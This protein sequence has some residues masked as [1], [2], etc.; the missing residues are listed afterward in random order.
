MVAGSL[1]LALL[2]RPAPA[3]EP[4]AP[5]AG[6][7]A[8]RT[9]TPPRIDGSLEDAAWQ[10]EALPLG[11][12]LTYNPLNGEKLVQ[13]TEVR[14]VYDDRAIYLAFRCRDPEPEK[15]RS[16]LSR[17]DQLW[18]DDWVG[19][20]LDPV[21]NGQSSYDLFVNAAGVQA[22]ILTTPSAG[23]NS[24]PD[25]VWD[26]A[27]RRTSE[28]YE[29]EIRL[30]LTTLRFKSGAEVRMGILF[31]RRVSRLGM[32]ASWPE[33]PAGKSFIERH[34]TLT[35]H[36]LKQPLTLEVI[37]S[38]TYSRRQTRVSPEAFGPADS[39]PD[40]GISVK[41]GVTSSTTIEGTV[42]PD[43]SQVESDAFQV[44]VNQRFPVFYSEKRPFFMEGMGT[45]ELAGVGGD[46]NMRTAVNTRV[47]QDPLWGGKASGTAGRATFALLAAGDEAPGRQVPGGVVNPFLGERRG[48]FIGRGQYSIGSSNYVGALLTDTEFGGGHNRVASTD[49]SLK[50]GNHFTS[51]TF[52]ASATRGAD[53]SETKDGLAGQLS[54]A[55]ET[56]P[57]VAVTQV[58][59]YDTDFQM[60]TAFVNQTGVTQGWSFV[61]PSFYPDPKK[62]P[63]LKRIVPFVF[64]RYGKDRVQGGSGYFVLPGIRV[65]TTRQGFFRLDAG[66]GREPWA[67]QVF[68]TSQ[69]RLMGGAQPFR[70][71]NVFTQA[72]FGRS[73]YYDPE[74]PYSGR[75]R[76]YQ[77]EVS[78]QPSSRFN[79]SV[80]WSHV[81][82]DR[83]STGENVYTVD[84]LNTRTTFQFDRH[85]FLR[86][87]VQ[88]DS[89][90]HRV[91]TDF[92]ASWELLPG[93]V[94]YAGYGSIVERRGWDG[95]GFT[96][97]P[98][99]DYRTSQ[100][101]FFFKASYIHR[102]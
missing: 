9:E 35:L 82:F 70:W 50:L 97:D 33:V 59:H 40:I 43:F 73:I 36:D 14:V 66:W 4:P 2:A 23:E 47:I 87:I 30:P 19:L 90:R 91:L 1:L 12:W 44:E 24:A 65:H 57:I 80:S 78:L 5:R 48:Y 63:W 52:L 18:N 25:W 20:S 75:E 81:R 21:G 98:A 34:A 7:E 83:A 46:A 54:Y 68:P 79:Q 41:Y 11:D 15:V 64:T 99:G 58:E 27:G 45:F 62:T 77:A 72:R 61:A 53:G 85:F 51:G 3:Q 22:D 28:G 26:S 76:S 6:I 69:V 95:S 88:Y 94:A 31:W 13:T 101:G 84:I 60:D 32:S 74:E 71:L 8:S 39:D 67:G 38:A 102:F 42:N 92:L 17:R 100:R 37:P 56:K 10:G 86:A 29:A 16:T 93:T 96:D 49:L 55:Y 89:S